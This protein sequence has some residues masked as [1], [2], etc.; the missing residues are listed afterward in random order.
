MVARGGTLRKGPPVAR[1]GTPSGCGPSPPVEGAALARA[2]FIR[3]DGLAT[4][5]VFPSS[6]SSAVTLRCAPYIVRKNRTNSCAPAWR[7]SLTALLQRLSFRLEI[8]SGAWCRA[9]PTTQT[10][11]PGSS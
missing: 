7:S 3:L 6:R 5:A 2:A 10:Y 4:W 1:E 8:P 9:I 11:W